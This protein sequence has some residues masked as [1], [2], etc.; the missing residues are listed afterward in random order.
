[1][2]ADESDDCHASQGAAPA[3]PASA[4]PTGAWGVID[5]AA[6]DSWATRLGAIAVVQLAAVNADD[7]PFYQA[8]VHIVLVAL[9]VLTTGALVL[10]I[11]DAMRE[12]S[13]PWNPRAWL[14]PALLVAAA[15]MPAALAFAALASLVNWV[16]DGWNMLRLCPAGRCSRRGCC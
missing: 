4:P 9:V 8:L 13:S 3:L 5:R 16:L 2:P 6:I 12:P 15:V 1:M 10:A 14:L 7:T 11:R